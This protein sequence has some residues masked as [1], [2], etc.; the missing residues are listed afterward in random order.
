MRC[1]IIRKTSRS[2]IDDVPDLV[3]CMVVMCIQFRIYIEMWRSVWATI[4]IN[5]CD[6][7]LEKSKSKSVHNLNVRSGGQETMSQTE[8]PIDENVQH[9]RR[10]HHRPTL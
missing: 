9:R 2:H 7:H 4:F 10:R 1:N 5:E 8:K 3:A 6:H